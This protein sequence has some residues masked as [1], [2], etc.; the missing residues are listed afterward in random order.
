[1]RQIKTELYIAVGDERS[2]LSEEAWELFLS[3]IVTS[4]FPKGITVLPGSGQWFNRHLGKHQNLKLKVVVIIHEST[5]R[6]RE[7]IEEIRS[8]WK[9]RYPCESVLKVEQE[10]EVSF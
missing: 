7:K 6:D 9:D 4:R 8:T 2:E 5:P 10:V 3:E 1:M